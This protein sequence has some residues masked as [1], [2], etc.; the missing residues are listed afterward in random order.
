V[1][2]A[3]WYEDTGQPGQ[4][5]WWDGTQWTVDTTPMPSVPPGDPPAPAAP[6]ASAGGTAPPD[7]VRPAAGDFATVLP[8]LGPAPAPGGG[9]PDRGSPDPR[10]AA[11]PGLPRSL[12]PRPPAPGVSAASPVDRRRTVLIVVGVAVAV[13]VVAVAVAVGLT[14]G[15]GS[16][17]RRTAV[18]TPPTAPDVTTSPT[19]PAATTT[20]TVPDAADEFESAV[21][22]GS[23][24]V[25][26]YR[27]HP[28]S[29]LQF[30][31]AACDLLRTHS[32]VVVVW[33]DTIAPG[34]GG[35]SPVQPL[36]GASFV[37][38]AERYLCPSSA[39]GALTGRLVQRVGVLPRAFG[40]GGVPAA[41]DEA[42]TGVTAYACQLLVTG[43]SGAVVRRDIA[44]ALRGDKYALSPVV[45][46]R[47]A[48]IGIGTVCPADLPAWSRAHR[49]GSA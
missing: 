33:Y 31:R 30:G 28:R 49:G 7:L 21:Q 1:P 18:T 5:R 12:P 38:D 36:P 26:G 19:R 29:L 44:T 27:A 9:G 11:P 2:D 41:A 17:V 34:P 42:G 22:S 40:R 45:A 47:A 48:T 23:H 46:T 14:S 25:T 15:G 3:G 16:H 24:P 13:L 32:P 37:A 6:A 39:V 43:S 8:E 35:T 10:A 20:T 4:L